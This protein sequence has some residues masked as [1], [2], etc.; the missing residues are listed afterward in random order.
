RAAKVRDIATGVSTH[1][2]D[3]RQYDKKCSDILYPYGPEEKQVK[4][5]VRY[6]RRAGHHH[7]IHRGR[8]AHHSACRYVL[9]IIG[10][11]IIRQK[12]GNAAR[13]ETQYVYRH[14]FVAAQVL[15]EQPSEPVEHKHIEQDVK[16][17]G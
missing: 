1:G 11:K 17:A 3:K 14:Q 2:A 4:S 7:G 5:I 8:C 15:R 13:Q 6:Q 16:Y 12:E 9:L 10:Y